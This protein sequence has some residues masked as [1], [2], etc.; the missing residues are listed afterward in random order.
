MGFT[1]SFG[2]RPA[3]LHSSM[4]GIRLSSINLRAVSRTRRSSSVSSESNSRKSTPRNLMAIRLLVS[5]S[6]RAQGQALEQWKLLKVTKR[7]K[8]VKPAPDLVVAF[9][10]RRP[11]QKEGQ[12]HFLRD[13]RID[14]VARRHQLCPSHPEH[15]RAR[16]RKVNV[17]AALHLITETI[18][19]RGLPRLWAAANPATLRT[20]LCSADSADVQPAGYPA[21][22]HPRRCPTTPRARE[23]QPRARDID[24]SRGDRI[25]SV[26]LRKPR[27][28]RQWFPRPGFVAWHWHRGP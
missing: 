11:Q 6:C 10:G 27:R 16:S 15:E 7:N 23:F 20:T 12:Q 25:H 18:V 13:R 9:F 28:H 4:M 19:A 26:P 2:K 8:P 21:R 24:R 1:S 3:R 22:I 14:A 17:S 5:V